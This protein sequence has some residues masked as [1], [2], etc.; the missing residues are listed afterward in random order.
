[1]QKFSQQQ[2][3]VLETSFRLNYFPSRTTLK[4]LALQTG[5]DENR[6]NRWFI[7]KRHR[8][9]KGKGN[10][11]NLFVSVH[12]HVDTYVLYINTINEH[13]AIYVC[14]FVQENSICKV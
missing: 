1:M 10:E 11:H 8:S 4:E 12:V 14:T 2:I 7:M 5:L 3:S 13:L 6:V 9:R